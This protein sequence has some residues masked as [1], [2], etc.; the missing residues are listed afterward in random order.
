MQKLIQS[1]IKVT[2]TWSPQEIPKVVDTLIQDWKQV[3]DTIVDLPKEQQTFRNC[4]T[5]FAL[6]EGHFQTGSSNCYLLSQVSTNKAI[7]EASLIA[8]KQ[9]E[10]CK[11]S[12]NLYRSGSIS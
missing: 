1:Y 7:R 5:P 6:A 12:Q 2:W 11:Y 9:L 10:V 3:Q 4:I 8:N